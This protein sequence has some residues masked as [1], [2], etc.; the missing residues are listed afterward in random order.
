MIFLPL[1]MPF[2]CF[3]RWQV[4]PERQAIQADRGEPELPVLLR[5]VRGILADFYNI[6]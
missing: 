1:K 3:L 4:C 2:K 6:P 5:G